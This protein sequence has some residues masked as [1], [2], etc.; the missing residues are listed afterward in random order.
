MKVRVIS[1]LVAF[2]IFIP[3]IWLGSYPFA[4][5]MG[6]LS[7][8]A[9]KEIIDLGDEYLKVPSCVKL[10]GLLSILY[11]VLGNYGHYSLDLSIGYAR[12]F[13]PLILLLL[14]TVFYKKDKYPTKDAFS[15]LGIVY[16]IGFLFN[17]LIA[18]RNVKL[19]ILIYLLGVT[20]LTD[21]FAYAVGMLIGKHKMSKL[22]PKKSWE[23]FVGGLI[24]GVATGLIIY[25]NL[26]GP[27]SFRLLI[28]TILISLAGQVGDL[29]YSKIKRENNIKDFSNIMPG[30]GG[31]LDRVDSLSFVVFT[32]I[33]IYWL[34]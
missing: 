6:I 23:G 5:A 3:L 29:F 12:L 22:S 2:L 9:Y 15:L 27:F 19:A 28:I 14:P 17:V 21:T 31:I 16:L 33:V 10:L 4:I 11:L 24:G 1:A 25:T 30:H 8:L 7:I 13:L 20:I 34:F 18:I 32:Y 26:V